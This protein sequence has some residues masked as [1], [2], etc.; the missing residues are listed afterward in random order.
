MHRLPVADDRAGRHSY[1]SG[2]LEGAARGNT[3]D[4]DGVGRFRVE[5]YRKSD[6]S[7]FRCW[8]TVDTGNGECGA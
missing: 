3:R 7:K 4:G 5:H 6:G 8:S 2:A 1:P